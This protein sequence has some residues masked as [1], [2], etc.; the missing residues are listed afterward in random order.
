MDNR[1]VRIG[2]NR[3]TNHN[4]KKEL[5]IKNKR[6][7]T[8]FEII[9]LENLFYS[10]AEFKRGK[11]NK[12][13]VQEFAL[14]LEDNIFEL[15]NDL[16]NNLYQHSKYTSFFISDPKLRCINKAKVRDRLLHQA[17]FKIIEPIFEKIFIFDSYS[18]RKNKGTHRAIK[19]F[20]KMAWKLS[21][22]NTRTVW[23]LK[24]D[25]KKFFDSIDHNILLRLIKLKVTNRK[26][27]ELIEKVIYSFREN[28]ETGIPLGNLTSQLFS[29]IYLNELDQFIKRGLKIKNYIRYADD[30]VI[31]SD[32]RDNL[33]KV[34]L[35]IDEFLKSELNLRFHPEKVIMEKWN[36]GV[37]FLGY[38]SFPYYTILRTKTKNR[39]L[40][41]IAI[42]INCWRS[43]EIDTKS[44]SQTLQS[45][46]GVLK[47][48]CWRKILKDVKEIVKQNKL[49]TI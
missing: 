11:E 2:P 19:R 23:V 18:S 21:K 28:E 6:G 7:D 14:N 20:Q 27:V 40:K 4:H 10:W 15:H 22:N 30:F 32:E 1:D 25:I 46:M 36:S 12:K 37:D 13:D 3:V 5:K 24:C 35:K 44:F 17:I 31:L 29:N 8:F 45:Y 16:K 39:M 34:F 9:S 42:K 26:T 48:C 38:V 43:K 49:L 47:W 33:E 41:K